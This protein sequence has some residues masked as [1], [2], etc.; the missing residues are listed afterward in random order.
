[1][2]QQYLF[3][4]F[5]NLYWFP[6]VLADGLVE[7]GLALNDRVHRLFLISDVAHNSGS[8]AAS[9]AWC[10]RREFESHLPAVSMGV[11]REPEQT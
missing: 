11:N 9:S 2:K 8:V 1:M 3:L 6:K 5:W 4:F 7:D 10:Y